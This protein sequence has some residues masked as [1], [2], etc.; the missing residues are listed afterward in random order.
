MP[1]MGMSS[2]GWFMGFKLHLVINNKAQIIAIKITKG[3]KSDLSALD[4]ITKNLHGKLF[5]DK[6][7]ISK[8]WWDKLFARGLRLFTGLRKDMKNYLLELEDKMLLR[9]RSLIEGVFNV[10]KNSM[11]LEQTRS[12]S[13]VNYLVHILACISAYAIQKSNVNLSLPSINS[14]NQ[15]IRK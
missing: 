5:G 9:K 14:R 11:N 2:Y 12:R 3:N 8:E 15:T 10:L 4:N 1:K 6:G 13:P 7:Y